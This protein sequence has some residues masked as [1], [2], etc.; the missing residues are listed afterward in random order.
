MPSTSGAGRPGSLR[1]S[2]ARIPNGMG[3]PIPDKTLLIHTEQGAG[4]AIQFAR[5]LPLAAQRCQKLI[6]V[7]R[8]DLIPVFATCRALPRSAKPGQITCD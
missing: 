6:L 8:A 2:S 5:F 1:R 7:C 3:S 4:D